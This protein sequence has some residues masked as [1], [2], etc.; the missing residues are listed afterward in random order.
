M[1]H[2]RNPPLPLPCA[3]NAEPVSPQPQTPPQTPPL[4]PLPFIPSLPMSPPHTRNGKS[5]RDSPS[6]ALIAKS[7]GA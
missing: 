3:P 7:I 5:Y 4:T 1:S 6:S 2:E